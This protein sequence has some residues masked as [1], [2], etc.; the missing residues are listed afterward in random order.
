[1]GD[2]L[3]DVRVHHKEPIA[4]RVVAGAYAV[5]EDFEPV[6]ASR[7]GMRA[8]VLDAAELGA[9]AAAAL[10]LNYEPDRCGL[11]RWRPRSCWTCV[12]RSMAVRTSGRPPTGS[13]RR[14]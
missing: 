2:R 9:F 6:Q 11:R 12:G 13:R 7:D 1:M 3:A 5:L 10:A 4:E 14:R 8:V